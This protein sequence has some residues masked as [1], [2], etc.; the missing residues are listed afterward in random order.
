M[1]LEQDGGMVVELKEG[2]NPDQAQIHPV[3]TISTEP[4]NLKD[5]AAFTAYHFSFGNYVHTE[6]V[7]MSYN[8]FTNEDDIEKTVVRELSMLDQLTIRAIIQH[9]NNN[10]PDTVYA[11][12]KKLPSMVIENTNE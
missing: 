2:G 6:S 10:P 12:I 7:G 11:V 1:P 8:P 5:F 9:Y 4:F 3:V